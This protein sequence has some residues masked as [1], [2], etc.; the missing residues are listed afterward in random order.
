L[1][2]CAGRHAPDFGGR[3]KPVNHYADAPQEIPLHQAYVFR[4]SPMDG[5]LKGMLTRW[6]ADRKMTLAYRHP[7][8]YTLTT[9]VAR[10]D[11]PD[12]QVAAASL[13]SIYA[14]QG[15]SV[16]IE[17]NQILVGLVETD[18]TGQPD[19]DPGPQEIPAKV[20]EVP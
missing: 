17:G 18:G 20:A 15:V 11:T 19:V 1:T 16:A 10:I 3:W 14:P 12:I 6:A 8:D 13:G 2:A 7:S 5:T 9:P 4:A